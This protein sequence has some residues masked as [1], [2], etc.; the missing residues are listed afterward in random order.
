MKSRQNFISL[1]FLAS[2]AVI[3]FAISHKP[4][5]EKNLSSSNTKNFLPVPNDHYLQNV[6]SIFNNRCVVC[7]SCAE[8]PCQLLLTSFAGVSRGATDHD[9]LDFRVKKRPPTR[10]KDALSEAEWRQKG[11]FGVKEELLLNFITLGLKNNDGFLLNNNEERPL[12]GNKCVSS[13]K[14]FYKLTSKISGMGMPFGLPALSPEEFQIMYQWVKD[15]A[16]GPSPEAIAELSKSTDPAQI[17]SWESFF[18][19]PDIKSKLSAR[20]IY[21]HVFAAHLHFANTPYNEFYELVRSRTPSPN[22]IDEIVT[23]RPYDDP[24]YY[25]FSYRLRRVTDTIVQKMHVRWELS[26]QVLARLEALFINADWGNSNIADPGYESPSPF[27]NFAAIPPKIRYRFLLE[28]SQMIVNGMTRGPV[29]TG[30]TATYA[31]RDQ[32]WIFFIDPDQDVTVIEP[33]LSLDHQPFADRNWFNDMSDK[34]AYEAAMRRLKPKGFSVSD[35]WNG[36]GNNPNAT[37]T[38]LRHDQSATVHQGLIGGYPETVWV[39]NYSN[40]ERLYYDLVADFIPWG[41]L[42]E[43]LST[44]KFM[45]RLRNEAEERFLTFL[46]EIYRKELRDSWNEGIGRLGT[47]LPALRTRGR[48]ADTQV[49][50]KDPMG[51]LVTQLAARVPKDHLGRNDLSSYRSEAP[52]LPGRILGQQE[53]EQALSSLLNQPGKPFAQ[54]L[55]NISYLIL[56]DKPWIYTLIPHRGYYFNNFATLEKLSRNKSKDELSAFRGIVGDRPEFFFHLYTKDVR[57]FV[58]ELSSL[59]N[60]SDWVVFKSRYG[61]RRN[62]QKFWPTLDYVHN[63]MRENTPLESGLLDVRN[64]DVTDKIF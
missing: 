9:L 47:Y 28:N 59:D 17:S 43:N 54:Y 16:K 4:L 26:P 36:D 24:K 33:N 12:K 42:K 10:L 5:E 29:C 35:I 53:L 58:L 20:Y 3:V 63:W 15:G 8:A 52:K 1:V 25:N 38:V 7:H 11:F 14:E 45:S 57:Q 34:N 37:L 23:E 49:D 18:N 32:F 46:P 40:F 60:E 2:L 39:V 64:Y 30:R 51:S 55:P 27:I 48:E 41:S 44:W 13:T 56:A 21:E 61:I 6:Q 62:S 19:R 31:I 50:P 22:P